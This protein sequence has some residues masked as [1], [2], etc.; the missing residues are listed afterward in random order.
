MGENASELFYEG[1]HLS[2][3][4]ERA[5]GR[6]VWRFEGECSAR[7]KSLKEV[8]DSVVERVSGDAKPVALDLRKTGY[9]A[10]P[11]IGFL[12]TL[13]ARLADRN[14]VLELWGPNE[15]VKDLLGIV[16]IASGV[17]IYAAE[18]TPPELGG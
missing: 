15:K 3:A 16:G 18:E 8:L 1:G 2:I 4:V 13:V 5:Y 7:V 17:K 10:S 12:V 14:Q 9:V 6:L 11:F